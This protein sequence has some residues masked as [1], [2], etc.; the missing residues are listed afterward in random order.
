MY[1]LGRRTS[2]VEKI[3]FASSSSLYHRFL[4]S[5]TALQAHIDTDI[6]LR[7]EAVR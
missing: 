7:P 2:Q 6:T 4:P 3:V 1:N 5:H